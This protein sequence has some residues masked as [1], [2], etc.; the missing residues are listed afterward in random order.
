[1]ARLLEAVVTDGQF[2]SVVG[3]AD[4]QGLL[5]A[6]ASAWSLAYYLIKAR[7]PGM[8]EFYKQLS[9]LPRDLEVDNKALLACFG[10]AFNVANQ[11]NDGV[12]PAAFEQLAKDWLAYLKSEPL[13]GAELGL[14]RELNPGGAPGNPAGAAGTP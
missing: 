11:T 13:P 12:D 10:R 1:A 9:A 14:E 4:R 3:G 6:R 7:L 5:R 2:N 8:L